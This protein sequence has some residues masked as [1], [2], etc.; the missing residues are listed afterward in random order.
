MRSIA[1]LLMMKKF[2]PS[3]AVLPPGYED[4][5]YCPPE[6]CD[7]KITHDPG[8]V[9]P[10]SSFHECYMPSTG[11]VV[12]EVWTGSLSQVAAPQGWV[13]T[14]VSCTTLI[15]PSG[16]FQ[17]GAKEEGGVTKCVLCLNDT[18]DFS[19]EY[20]SCG[21]ACVN[22]SVCACADDECCTE[23]PCCFPCDGAGS[24]ECTSLDCAFDPSDCGITICVDD[25][26]NQGSNEIL[27]CED[28]PNFKKGR[29]ITCDSITEKRTKSFKSAKSR[30]A[31]LCLDEEVASNCPMACGQCSPSDTSTN[32][33]AVEEDQVNNSIPLPFDVEIIC[34][35]FGVTQ[36]DTAI[37]AIQ[38]NDAQTF[39]LSCDPGSH[40]KS[41][42]YLLNDQ[43][44]YFPYRYGV[45]G[46]SESMKAEC[47][48]S[49]M[50]FEIDDTVYNAC[51]SI[52]DDA[53]NALAS[54]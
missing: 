9:G 29:S 2:I 37:R 6:Y 12:D 30:K 46:A 8:F 19:N 53:C 31:H 49:D 3:Q 27:S 52:M 22:E 42:T 33:T 50:H 10:L 14:P 51:K 28:N 7:R 48:V 38:N 16:T 41:I 54:V 1:F 39:V 4:V 18:F 35:C 25:T 47:F 36:L 34:T 26:G 23:N 15:C 40:Y 43:D 13:A 24:V 45:S 44:P 11:D 17:V 5:M 21:V 32:L 20:S